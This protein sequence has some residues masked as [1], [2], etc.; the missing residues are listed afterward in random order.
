MDL[1]TKDSLALRVALENARRLKVIARIERR[2]FS[3]LIQDAKPRQ[4]AIVNSI[5]GSEERK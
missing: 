5:L 2:T 3:E 4:L 1:A